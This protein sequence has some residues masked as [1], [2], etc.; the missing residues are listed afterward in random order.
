MSDLRRATILTTRENYRLRSLRTIVRPRLHPTLERKTRHSKCG[1]CLLWVQKISK[2]RSN[3]PFVFDASSTTFVIGTRHN[4]TT[5]TGRF[6]LP[7]VIVGQQDG[8]AD[9]ITT[10]FDSSKYFTILRIPD[11]GKLVMLS[12][13]SW[14]WLIWATTYPAIEG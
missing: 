8:V 5:L 12:D 6:K 9:L 7:R 14:K 2:Q 11:V 4:G 13:S 10:S 1:C 3:R